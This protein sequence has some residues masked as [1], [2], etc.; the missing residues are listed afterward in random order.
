MKKNLKLLFGLI[1]SIKYFYVSR[2]F[3]KTADMF[4]YI[5]SKIFYT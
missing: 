1:D 4:K 5:Y 3:D 2:F